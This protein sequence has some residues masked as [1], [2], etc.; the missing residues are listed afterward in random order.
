MS[1]NSTVYPKLFENLNSKLEFIFF[2]LSFSDDVNV[3][4]RQRLSSNSQ[5]TACELD[6]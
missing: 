1:H 5:D 6:Y 4:H 3:H 2:S